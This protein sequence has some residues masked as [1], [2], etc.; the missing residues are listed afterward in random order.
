VS[1][2]NDFGVHELRSFLALPFLRQRMGSLSKQLDEKLS[3]LTEARAAFDARALPDYAEFTKSLNQGPAQNRQ[4]RP[5]AQAASAHGPAAPSGAAAAAAAATAKHG[6]TE[7]TGAAKSKARVVVVRERA[8]P[9]PTQAPMQTAPPFPPKPTSAPSGGSGGNTASRTAGASS[10]AMGASAQGTP[11]SAA[12]APAPARASGAVA[13]AMD[14]PARGAQKQPTGTLK[15]SN[16]SD[17]DN[18]LDTAELGGRLDDSFFD[19]D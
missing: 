8:A 1:C 17:S 9:P 19:D 14:A 15:V 5:V 2:A 13:A 3:V 11:A 6:A 7:A 10:S 12:A 16:D 4:Q 18:Y